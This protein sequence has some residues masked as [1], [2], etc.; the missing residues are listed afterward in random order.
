MSFIAE[1]RHEARA[2]KIARIIFRLHL[3]ID[4][5]LSVPFHARQKEK[6]TLDWELAAQCQM[7]GLPT[8]QSGPA[9]KAFPPVLAF[10]HIFPTRFWSDV[11]RC[12]DRVV[13]SIRLEEPRM[14]NDSRQILVYR[15]SKTFPVVF[16]VAE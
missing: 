1:N 11:Q 9:A 3:R 4:Q 15:V 8:R 7:G 13:A 2:K 10:D 14:F 16:K 6:H 5:Y 12:R